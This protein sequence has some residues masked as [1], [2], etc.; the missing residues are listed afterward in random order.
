MTNLPVL[1]T[2]VRELLA[3]GE[4]TRIPEPEV[5]DDPDNVDAFTEVGACDG[6]IAPTY[7]FNCAQISEVVRP[8]ERVV[9]LGCGPARQLAMVADLN[10]D[11]EFL[12]LD[13]SEPMLAKGQRHIDDLGLTNVELRKQDLT[14]LEFLDDHSVDA[15]ISTMTLHHLPDDEHLSRTFQEVARVLKK[16]GG[17]YLVDF[18]HLKS[19]RSIHTMANLHADRQPKPFTVDYFNSLKAA[20]SKKLFRDLTETHLVGRAQLYSTFPMPLMVAVKSPARNL[21]SGWVKDKLESRYGEF[22]KEQ[23]VDFGDLSRLFRLGG[24]KSE[25]LTG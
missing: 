25:L 24:L 21:S 17:L 14:S 13:L 7:L 6:V 5:M 18:G 9:D 8:G 19:E 23:R 15:V 4:G 16:D 1:A 12:G 2:V 10:P 11:T 20:F 22:S 3:R